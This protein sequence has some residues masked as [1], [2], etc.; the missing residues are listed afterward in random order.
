MNKKL[1]IY[2]RSTLIYFSFIV[3][4]FGSPFMYLSAALS[5]WAMTLLNENLIVF[6]T[7]ASLFMWT[8]ILFI[9][10]LF[11]F[12]FFACYIFKD[13]KSGLSGLYKRNVVFYENTI[14][15]FSYILKLINGVG[16]AFVLFFQD[17]LFSFF[18]DRFALNV[19]LNVSHIFFNLLLSSFVISVACLQIAFDKI[20][21][22]KLT[23]EKLKKVKYKIPKGKGKANYS[24]NKQKVK[25]TKSQ[26]LR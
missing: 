19:D 23:H 3:F 11:L 2:I 15:N 25:Y 10:L 5:L 12:S 1:I 9:I 6:N 22:Q 7:D 16:I 21:T 17:T 8:I 14:S 18:Y 13:I 20:F 4:V 26:E 24:H